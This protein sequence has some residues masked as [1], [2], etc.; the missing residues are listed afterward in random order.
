MG[1]YR[2]HPGKFIPAHPLLAV[3]VAAASI[4]GVLLAY[5]LGT[6]SQKHET[7]RV[8]LGVNVF[9]LLCGMAVGVGGIALALLPRGNNLSDDF[10]LMG[11]AASVAIG[12]LM[13]IGTNETIEKEKRHWKAVL[14]PSQ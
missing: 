14:N 10:I 9:G 12:G 6:A 5:C 3:S 8:G 1:L 7:D 11:V 4:S 2:H 13:I